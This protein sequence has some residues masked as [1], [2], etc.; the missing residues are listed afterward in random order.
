MGRDRVFLADEEGGGKTAT[1]FGTMFNPV[2]ESPFVPAAKKA[3]PLGGKAQEGTRIGA[4]FVEKTAVVVNNEGGTTSADAEK[5]EQQR[6]DDA[7]HPDG[8]SAVVTAKFSRESKDYEH[9]S[10]RPFSR[11]TTTTDPGPHQ[12]LP[13]TAS[14]LEVQLQNQK[15]FSSWL[16]PENSV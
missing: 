14:A 13:R 7:Q 9:D 3:P 1:V 6:V 2:D 11:R 12:A 10:H 4:S 8:A 16:L 5:Q 15:K